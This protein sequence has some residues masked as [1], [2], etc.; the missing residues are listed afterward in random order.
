[1]KRFLFTLCFVVFGTVSGAQAHSVWI[2]NFY[3]DAHVPPHA[4]VSIGWGHAL[5]MDDIPNSPNG[6]ILLDSFEVIGPDLHR[7]A[8]QKP[9]FEE[10]KPSQNTSDFDVY[11]GD[12][13]VQK[14]ALKADSKPGVYQFSAVSKPTFYTQYLDKKGRQR[15][16][17]KPRDEVKD[18]DKVLMSVKFQAF[19]K[20]YMTVK[21]WTQPAPLGHGLEIIPLTDLS[22]VHVG[23]LIQLK[24]LFNGEP[25][26]STAKSINYISASSPSFG[27]SDHFTL[28][29]Y[30][31]EGLAQFRV[32]GSGQWMIN[33]NLKDDVTK[34]GPLK[35]L[36]GKADQVYQAASLTFIVK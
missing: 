27:Q 3:S 35:D 36:Y 6:R 33:T 14:I 28:Q 17:L 7:T 31:M 21:E 20:S 12:L 19:A 1:M 18:I 15:L 4:M 30:I 11:P 34:D 24:V 16:A 25:V 22:N 32:Q 10:S 26:S 23:D 2:N 5:P 29:S 9:S 13:A 8:L